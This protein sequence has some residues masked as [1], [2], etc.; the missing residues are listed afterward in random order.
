MNQICLAYIDKSK[1]YTYLYTGKTSRKFQ[2]AA[3]D[4]LPVVYPVFYRSL[5]VFNL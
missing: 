2:S 4:F 5:Y 3:T 1:W